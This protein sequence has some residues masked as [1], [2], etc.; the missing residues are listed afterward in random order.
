MAKRALATP[1]KPAQKKQTAAKETSQSLSAFFGEIKPRARGAG[2]I[3]E[4]FPADFSIYSWNVNGVSATITKGDLPK[5]IAE[6]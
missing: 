2:P 4:K 3:Y 6:K 1:S 5:F